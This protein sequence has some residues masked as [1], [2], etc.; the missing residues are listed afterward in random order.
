MAPIHT[1]DELVAEVAREKA[2]ER[3]EIIEVEDDEGEEEEEPGMS[4]REI[5]SSITK[6]QKAL[7]VQGE[8]CVCTAKMLA[9]VKDEVA[10]EEI[11]NAQQTMLED[12]LD[13]SHTS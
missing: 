13:T 7:L 4:I 11:R 8:L 1:D 2:I 10:W 5:M 6:L 12:W 9:L 3:G